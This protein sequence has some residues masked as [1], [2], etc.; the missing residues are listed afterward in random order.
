MS[1]FRSNCSRDSCNVW[2]ITTDVRS[3][4]LTAVVPRIQVSCQVSKADGRVGSDSSV[5][6]THQAVHPGCTV[7]L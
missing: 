3:E 2:N 7:I 5:D 1:S 4:V 6:Y